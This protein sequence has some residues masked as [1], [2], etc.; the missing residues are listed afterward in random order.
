MREAPSKTRA[1]PERRAK[2][3][4]EAPERRPS[5]V[6]AARKGARDR[7]VRGARAEDKWRRMC[8]AKETQPSRAQHK[9]GRRQPKC[10]EAQPCCGGIQTTICSRPRNL[11]AEGRILAPGGAPSADVRAPFPTS[12]TPERLAD[13]D[14]GSTSA[15]CQGST[16]A[17]ARLPGQRIDKAGVVNAT[18]HLSNLILTPAG[19][20]STRQRPRC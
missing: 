10:G 11:R 18:R 17:I 20:R 2:S 3:A 13:C 1:T 12:P 14:S 6:R 19:R 4:R 7:R 9:L 5:G 16:D 8:M 15:L